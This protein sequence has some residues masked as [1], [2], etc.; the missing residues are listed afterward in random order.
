MKGLTGAQAVERLERRG[1]QVAV[2]RQGTGT[3]FV[4][5][6]VGRDQGRA[7]VAPHSPDSAPGGGRAL[8]SDSDRAALGRQMEEERN[9]ANASVQGDAPQW[10]LVHRDILTTDGG[11]AQ[12]GCFLALFS[13]IV[14]LVA[15]AIVASLVA[16]RVEVSGLLVGP[17]VGFVVGFFVIEPIALIAVYI[18]PLRDRLVPFAYGWMAIVPGAVTALTIIAITLWSTSGTA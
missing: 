13:A 14:G 11:Y 10:V 17:V 2:F 12:V 16:G 5:D 3:R 7:V 8:A 18:P 4:F 1:G 9:R 6:C 15:G